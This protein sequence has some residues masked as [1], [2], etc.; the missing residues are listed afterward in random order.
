MP[1]YFKKIDWFTFLEDAKQAVRMLKKRKSIVEL[2]NDIF[3][4]LDPDASDWDKRTSERVQNFQNDSL[5]AVLSRSNTEAYFAGRNEVLAE[6]RHLIEHLADDGIDWEE[7]GQSE[8]NRK[9]R[10]HPEAQPDTITD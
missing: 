9:R 6:Y 5:F 3:E 1:I 4:G 7:V 10:M 8:E 2:P